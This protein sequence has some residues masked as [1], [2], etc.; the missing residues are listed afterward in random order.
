ML[1]GR[2]K[3]IN[4]VYFPIDRPSPRNVSRLDMGALPLIDRMHRNGIYLDVEKTR[5][6]DSRLGIDQNILQESIDLLVGRHLNPGS[7]DQVAAFLYG[8]LG[9]DKELARHSEGR[10][11][12]KTTQSGARLSTDDETLALLAALPHHT[13]K[14]E[15]GRPLPFDPIPGLI[16]DWREVNKIRTTYTTKLPL[17]VNPYTNRIHTVFNPARTD[18]GRLSSSDPN[19][20]N[21]PARGD[22]GPMVRDCFWAQFAH[23]SGPQQTVLVS[24][25]LSQIEMVGAAHCSGDPKM[26]KVFLDGLDLH[27]FTAL[28]MFR[29]NE[30]DVQIED[31]EKKP[32]FHPSGT[33]PIP[34][35]VF[36]SKYRLP[37]KTLGFGILY[38][39]TP[40]GL[41]Q[42]ILNAGGP[43][44]AEEECALFIRGW[45][46]LYHGVYQWTSEQHSR[47]RRFGMVWDLLGRWRLIPEVF[48]SIEGVVNAGLRQAGN[49]PIQSFA[50]GII[51]LAMA[52]AEL[53]VQKYERFKAVICWPLLQIHDELIFEVSKTIVEEFRERMKELMCYC[54]TLDVPVNVS[55]DTAFSWGAL[56]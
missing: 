50:Q 37:A 14:D 3:L 27:T 35:K 25:D 49:M 42:Q 43:F 26:S 29:L 55:S 54:I 48:S 23:L 1:V 34:W 20:Q 17:K 56:K 10:Q 16:R 36:K 11:E 52:H 41:Q 15:D 32:T 40:K 18:T 45:Y 30:A 33:W 7:G 22:Y 8:E 13:D 53:L 46:A 47:A 4:G 44:W 6:L 5:E 12:V 39:V 21:I 38:G 31:P 28:S 24:C 19:L 9:L 2:Q 51:K